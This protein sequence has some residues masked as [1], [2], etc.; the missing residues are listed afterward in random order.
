MIFP[1]GRWP[2]FDPPVF[3]RLTA[4]CIGFA[5]PLAA[6]AQN[7]VPLTLADAERLAVRAEPGGRAIREQ[8]AALREHATV[9]G[10]LPS[11]VLRIGLNNYP[12]ESGGF[13]T[14]GMT[15]LNLGLRQAFPAGKALEL[16]EQRLQRLSDGL[17]EQAEAR[18]RNVLA[19]V[20]NAWLE[21]YFLDRAEALIRESRPFFAD[22]S[23][24]TRSLY[25]VGRRSQQDVLRAELELSRLD[26]RLVD[27]ERRRGQARA[28]LA[29]W[30]GAE[31]ARPVAADW[32][33]WP[34]LPP[35]EELHHRLDAHPLV[36]AAGAEVD[37]S[38]A[39]VGIAEARRKPQWS[40]DVGYGYR[41]GMLPGGQPRSDMVT[42]GVSVELPWFRK[43]SIDGALSAALRER[44]ATRAS[45]QRLQSELVR[46]LD[47]GYAEWRQLERRLHLYDTKILVQAR[48]QADSSLTAYQSDA[49]DFADVMRAYIGYLNTRIEHVRLKVD[50]AQAYVLLANLGGLSP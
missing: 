3:R 29:E 50:Q 40:L 20:R 14:E 12:I 13:S 47:A 41:E 32:P 24:T 34:A 2:V 38:D 49:G 6:A 23:D 15:Q 28:M 44:S 30:I 42:I 33:S 36:L 10:S 37:A 19:D 43:R 18:G 4:V 45:R 26:D 1:F 11:P 9:A 17:I 22:L 25:A 31:A 27:I 7:T 46:R 39:G 48:E 21:L 16:D 5:L 35:V 8:A